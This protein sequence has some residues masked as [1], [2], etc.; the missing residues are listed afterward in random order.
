M[1][2]EAVVEFRSQPCSGVV[3]VNAARM[4]VRF[5]RRRKCAFRRLFVFG[6]NGN[7]I[8]IPLFSCAQARMDLA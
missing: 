5:P 6:E 1:R 7:R 8:G 3:T 4:H 2:D